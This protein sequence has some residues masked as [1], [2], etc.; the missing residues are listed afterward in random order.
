MRQVLQAERTCTETLRQNVCVFLRNI[1]ESYQLE[2]IG[3]YPEV[4]LGQNV[5]LVSE[6]SKGNACYSTYQQSSVSIT[7]TTKTTIIATTAFNMQ[8]AH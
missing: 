2:N 5:G 7:T 6:R 3:K 8:S 1:K 4:S